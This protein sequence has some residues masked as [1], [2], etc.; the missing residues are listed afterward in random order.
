[1]KKKNKNKISKKPVQKD[2]KNAPTL[3]IQKEKD[4]AMDFAVK[5]YKKF[6]KMVKS[7]VLFGSVTKDNSVVGSDID[8]II[9]LDDA[10]ISWDDELIS[11]YREELEKLIKSNPYSKN[12]HINTI[13]LTTWFED[14]IRGDPIVINIIRNGEPLVDFGGFF[15]PLKYLLIQGKIRPS[16]EAIYTC[17]QRAPTHFARS[18]IA[19]LNSIEGLYWA[20]V[21]SS[22]AALIA[23]NVL[24]PS[25]E[26]IPSELKATFV[27]NKKLDMK[28]VLWFKDLLML[29]K[30]IN[31]SE[32]KEV[33]G[34]EIDEWQNRTQEF[35]QVMAKL[36]SEL[37]NISG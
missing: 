28:Y 22:H 13:K 14:L 8:I 37:I 27:E 7:I 19:Q 23:A 15:L 9:I 31:H 6:D 18:K 17:L 4:I 11:W 26:H 3:H 32:L 25:P 34:L 24:P 10:S 35:M 20:M 36:V 1:M 2:Y 16:A 33:K 12:L 21:D 5:A 30:K 29:H